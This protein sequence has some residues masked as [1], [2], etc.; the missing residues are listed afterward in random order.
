L[1]GTSGNI[2]IYVYIYICIY[3]SFPFFA[4]LFTFLFTYLFKEFFLKGKTPQ[5]PIG[6]HHA[7]NKNRHLRDVMTYFRYTPS[8]TRGTARGLGLRT[9]GRGSLKEKGTK[10]G[11]ATDFPFF[12]AS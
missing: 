7:F 6:D 10:Y 1:R 12:S 5:N 3:F 4:Y 9:S 11:V 8:C 2:L